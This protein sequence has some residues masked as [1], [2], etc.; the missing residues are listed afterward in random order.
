[1]T[2]NHHFVSAF[3]DFV[4]TVVFHDDNPYYV[5]VYSQQLFPLRV[6]YL[7]NRIKGLPFFDNPFHKYIYYSILSNYCPSY[8]LQM[9]Q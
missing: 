6:F 9:G 1:M 2:E 7:A 3:T 4:K 5:S 8:S